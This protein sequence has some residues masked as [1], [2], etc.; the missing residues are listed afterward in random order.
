MAISVKLLAFYC[1]LFQRSCD[2]VNTL[3][4]DVL[5]IEVK[6]QLEAAIQTYHDH[7]EASQAT[8]VHPQSPRAREEKGL[9]ECCASILI[10][11]CLACFGGHSA[12]DLPHFYDSFYFL[13]KVQ[14]APKLH[15]SH[16]PDEVIDLCENSYEAMDG[17]KQ[18]ASWK[19]TKYSIALINHLF[20]LLPPSATVITLYDVGCVLSRSLNQV[21]LNLLYHTMLMVYNYCNGTERL[22]SRFWSSSRQH[23]LWLIDRHAGAIDLEMHAD[24]GDWIR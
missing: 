3:W 18:K 5:Q 9:Q 11:H 7:V 17:K 1:S 10:Q 22:W 20:S 16:V 15:V 12:G 4:F 21:S 8:P 24:L 2:A 14:S 6:C 23:H 19:A 13:P